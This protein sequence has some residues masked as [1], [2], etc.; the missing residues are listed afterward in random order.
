MA[1]K[2]ITVGDR[3]F[4]LLPCPSIGLKVIGRNLREIGTPT[5]AGINALVDGIYYGV[6]RGAMD[7]ATITRDYFEW[8]IDAANVNDLML[9][10]AEVN[11]MTR[12]STEADQGEA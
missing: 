8:N 9:A 10:F 11:G 2:K 3:E 1:G 4:N 12:A 5:D 7:D 6:K